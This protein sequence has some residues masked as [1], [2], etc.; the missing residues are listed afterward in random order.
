MTNHIVVMRS[1]GGL[2]TRVFQIT[3]PAVSLH[4]SVTCKQ[5]KE[6]QIRWRQGARV[7]N[8]EINPKNQHCSTR[9]LF[10]TGGA[11]FPSVTEVNR[12]QEQSKTIQL[13]MNTHQ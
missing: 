8:M 3:L 1:R 12:E 5:Q 2:G 4:K 13:F 7:I 11:Q 6:H 10:L 9:C